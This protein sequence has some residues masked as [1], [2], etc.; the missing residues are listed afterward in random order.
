MCNIITIMNEIILITIYFTTPAI[1][2]WLTKKIELLNKIGVVVLSYLFG[3]SMALSGFLPENVLDL[4]NILNTIVIP[5]SIPLLLFSTDIKALKSL[6]GSFVKSLIIGLVSIVIS[7]V[8]GYYFFMQD[9]PIGNQIA[10]LLTG[11]YTGGTPNLASIKTA[12]DIDSSTYIL[13]HSTD[14]FIGVFYLLFFLTIAQKMLN[15][16]LPKHSALAT[17]KDYSE[18]HLEEIDIISN[19]SSNKRKESILAISVS[20]VVFGVGGGL[21][22]LF[23]KEYGTTIAILS[24]TTISILLSFY[25]PINKI[26]QSFSI[27]MYLILVFSII[28]SS[29]VNFEAIGFET[30]NLLYYITW[31]MIAT[32]VLQV[33]FAK[34]FG[35]DSDITIITATALS[36]S[37]PFVPVVA[38]ALNNKNIVFPGIT[39]GIIG[40][41]IGNYLGVFMAYILK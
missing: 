34:I 38:G 4:Q 3:I 17:S 32:F 24:I 33:I 11:V 1:L 7:I 31:A 22:L 10:G 36:M 16:F 5:I 6:T 12:L 39:I 2:V 26:K 8:S 40:Y 9:S 21:S 19:F 20:V 29:M 41:V 27:G 28:V 13:V 14:L 25:K 37:P 35:I 30:L 23:P 18:N 15:K